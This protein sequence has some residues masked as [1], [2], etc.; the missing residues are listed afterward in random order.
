MKLSVVIPCYNEASTI[1]AIIDAVRASPYPDKEIIVVDDGSTDGTRRHL[2]GDLRSRIDRVIFHEYNQGK[3]A[4][5][6]TGIRAATG[7][8]VIIQDADLEY[9]PQEYPLMVEP[10]LRNKADAV[11]RIAVWRQR[12]APGVVF[13]ASGRQRLSDLAVEC[14]H[15]PQSDGYGNLLQG[16]PPRADPRHRD[17]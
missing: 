12:S 8:I 2:H 6:R 4:A 15:Q 14:L 11:F 1:A 10:I 3:G 7:D 5:L 9:D 13:L 17:R 16:V